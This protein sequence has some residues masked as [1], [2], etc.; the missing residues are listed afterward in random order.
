ME[1]Q[2]LHR[3]RLQSHPS[4]AI[5]GIMG[6]TGQKT[7]QI[8]LLSL[9]LMILLFL[10]TNDST[11]FFAQTLCLQY[12]DHAEHLRGFTARGEHLE[13]LERFLMILYILYGLS[14]LSCLSILYC[15]ENLSILS[16]LNRLIRSK[17]NVYVC[18]C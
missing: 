7:D 18:L 16:Y 6:V 8:V 14:C 5:L 9:F 15:L 3:L 17:K 12:A 4:L 10:E 1:L 2:H 11:V 13:H